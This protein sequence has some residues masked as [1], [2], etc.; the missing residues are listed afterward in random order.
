MSKIDNIFSIKCESWKKLLINFCFGD[1]LLIKYTV[2]YASVFLNILSFETKVFSSEISIAGEK[3]VL[4]NSGC[5]MLKVF[6]IYVSFVSGYPNN[7]TKK[8]IYSMV[9]FSL[10]FLA[11]VFRISIFAIVTAY[12]PGF[13]SFIHNYSTYII[14]YPVIF[15][16]WLLLIKKS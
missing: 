12:I 3:S 16:L 5:N 7:I 9:G 1:F 4:I 14:F 2:N 8:L 15:G 6:G 11:N 10:L 13:W